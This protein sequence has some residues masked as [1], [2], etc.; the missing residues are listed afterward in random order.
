MLFRAPPTF[1]NVI[2][3]RKSQMAGWNLF[4]SLNTLLT[5]LPGRLA[6][7]GVNAFTIP[8][9]GDREQQH[10]KQDGAFS[11]GKSSCEWNLA[12]SV[13]GCNPDV[14]HRCTTRVFVRQL[15]SPSLPWWLCRCCHYLLRSENHWVN[16]VHFFR[17]GKKRRSRS[18]KTNRGDQDERNVSS[19]VQ[20]LHPLGE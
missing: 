15:F 5:S 9:G 4:P 16:G 20:R 12:P 7:S 14:S 1:E 11:E 13:L 3:L 18:K 19:A 6:P 17:V 8:S 10:Y 2:L